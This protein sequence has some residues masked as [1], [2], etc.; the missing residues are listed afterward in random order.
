MK[1]PAGICGMILL[2]ILLAGCGTSSAPRAE[3]SS[4]AAKAEPGVGQPVEAGDVTV[5]V[6][7][8]AASQGDDFSTPA[9]GSQYIVVDLEVDNAGTA[10]YPF[11]TMVML[12]IVT[13]AGYEYSQAMY[14]PE[15]KFPNGDIPGSG[16][17][18]GN[19]AFEV[20]V[21]IGTMSLQFSPVTGD[22]VRIKLQ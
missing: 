12:S 10:G 20:P 4:P 18:R 9:E 19:V 22:S 8:W 11:S 5:T 15:P 2:V 6:H 13:P 1:K 14:F 7:T 17:A 21:N 3:K 16:K